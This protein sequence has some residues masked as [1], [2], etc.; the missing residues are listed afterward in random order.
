M[1][2]K[3]CSNHSGDRRPLRLEGTHS[4]LRPINIVA[5]HCK[6]GDIDRGDA[7]AV[8]NGLA[9]AHTTVEEAQLIIQMQSAFVNIVSA[10]RRSH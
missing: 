1:F 8:R 6:A 3:K 5:C 4:N 7:T 10:K 2:S 9:I